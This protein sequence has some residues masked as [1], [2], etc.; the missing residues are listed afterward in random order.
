MGD[1]IHVNGP[2][3]FIGSMAGTMEILGDIVTPIDVQWEADAA[4]DANSPDDAL[5]AAEP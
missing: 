3:G 5:L 2:E 1:E 4:A